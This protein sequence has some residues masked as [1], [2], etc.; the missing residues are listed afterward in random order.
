MSRDHIHHIDH[1]IIKTCQLI[2]T[3][4]DGSTTGA[5]KG[6][7][8]VNGQGKITRIP[9]GT[10]GQLLA[11][12]TASSNGIGWITSSASSAPNYQ[13]LTTANG[14]IVADTL[15]FI[16]LNAISGSTDAY[17]IEI[18][19]SGNYSN[20]LDNTGVSSGHL[21][22]ITI[23]YMSSGGRYRLYSNH[24]VYNDNNFGYFEMD[25]VGQGVQLLYTTRGWAVVGGG[26]AIL[27]A[28]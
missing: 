26:G 22:I 5:G 10:D 18:N 4:D 17:A 27:G 3:T 9:G 13:L 16:S 8:A 15:D 23:I 20:S 19:S 11:R 12:T 24:C 6:V 28:T 7:L 14:T 2:D 25:S 21:L 1:V